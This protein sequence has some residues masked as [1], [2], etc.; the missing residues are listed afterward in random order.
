MVVPERERGT[1]IDTKMYSMCKVLKKRNYYL[2]YTVSK[3]DA[4]CCFHLS[5]VYMLHRSHNSAQVSDLK[6]DLKTPETP[7]SSYHTF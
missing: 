7:A 6:N 3:A 4:K 1:D 2:L 5:A